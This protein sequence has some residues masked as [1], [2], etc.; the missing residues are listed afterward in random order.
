ML[1]PVVNVCGGFAMKLQMLVIAGPDDGRLYTLQPGPFLMMG[2]GTSS[3]YHL[4]DPNVSRSHCQIVM[5]DGQV[6]VIDDD[7]E[8]GTFVNGQ[9]VARQVLRLGDIV[10]LGDTQL[11]LLDAECSQKTALASAPAASTVLANLKDLSGKT[12][13]HFELGSVLG[14]GP[15]SMVFQ[16]RDTK[17]NRTVAL[18]ILRQEITRDETEVH[19]FVKAMK[20]LLPL[21]HPHLVPVLGAGKVGPH[22][23]VAMEHIDGDSLLQVIENLGGGASL[24]WR[25]AWRMAL[26]IGKALAFAQEQQLV[27]RHLTPSNIFLSRGDGQFRL[28]DLLLAWGEEYTLNQASPRKGLLASHVA[29]LSPEGTHSLSKTDGR[30]DLYSLGA[31]SYTLL[32]GRP[33]VEGRTLIEMVGQIRHTDPVKPSQTNKT[34]SPRF[35][36]AVLKLLARKPADRYQSAGELVAELEKIG[37]GL[38]VKV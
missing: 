32:T 37:R 34:I 15:A 28:G 38:N 4:K 10:K 2:R 12:L 19:R 13:G 24:D 14:E 26:H 17:D 16:A 18:K 29:Y 31:V 33:P 21:H 3:Y 36:Q 25:Y 35:E 9:K 8:T 1:A 27:H 23:W 6:T 30:S 11:R 20:I 5:E 7:S 22:C